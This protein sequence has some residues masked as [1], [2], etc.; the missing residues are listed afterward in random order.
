MST[1]IYQS[2]IETPTEESREWLRPLM[3]GNLTRMV[4]V[5][6]HLLAV[7]SALSLHHIW[8]YPNFDEVSSRGAA[9]STETLRSGSATGFFANPNFINPA[10]APA[11][12]SADPDG[13]I[14]DKIEIPFTSPFCSALQLT[15]RFQAHEHNLDPS[16]TYYQE[17]FD[18]PYAISAQLGTNNTVINNISEFIE[19]LNDAAIGYTGVPEGE[20]PNR[21]VP[22][23]HT[24][25]RAGTIFD[26]SIRF[27]L[28]DKN[29][30]IIDPAS[31]S[32]WA[33]TLSHNGQG[34]RLGEGLVRS[35]GTDAFPIREINLTIPATSPASHSL[36]PRAL[37]Y[38]SKSFTGEAV[39]LEIGYLYARPLSLSVNEL[40]P[41][42]LEASNFSSPPL[43][44]ADFPTNQP[45]SNESDGVA[46][47]YYYYGHLYLR[48]QVATNGSNGLVFFPEPPTST[49][50]FTGMDLSASG[51]AGNPD[52]NLLGCSGTSFEYQSHCYG[53]TAG[54]ELTKLGGTVAGFTGIPSPGDFSTQNTWTI[55][56]ASDTTYPNMGELV[57]QNG[58]RVWHSAMGNWPNHVVAVSSGQ[59][60]SIVEVGR[61]PTG[62]ENGFVRVPVSSVTSWGNAVANGDAKT[63]VF[64]AIF[65]ST[66]T[67]GADVYSAQQGDGGAAGYLKDFSGITQTPGIISILQSSVSLDDIKAAMDAAGIP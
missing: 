7:K 29:G 11:W 35:S 57:L 36:A 52:F 67:T 40:P 39:T 54:G 32:G 53:T 23:R 18:I 58:G 63:G 34:L 25:D 61:V 51:I 42:M 17:L 48:F 55:Q 9:A 66:I 62:V 31:G 8:H 4:E 43:F 60:Y 1:T 49:W 46:E 27:R 6:N 44:P 14:V 19:Y 21:K 5:A 16:S 38:G 15:L 2:R 59:P 33:V 45:T 64:F 41:L 12:Y 37:S 13:L 26:C 20:P 22:S 3:G 24:I 65:D 28:K 47:V 50:P 56:P 30:N 10:E